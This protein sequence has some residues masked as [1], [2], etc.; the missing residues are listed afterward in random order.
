MAEQGWGRLENYRVVSQSVSPGEHV[1]AG[2]PVTLKLD[3]PV[4]RGPLGSMVEPVNHPT[5]IRI[6]NLVGQDYRQAMAAGDAFKTGI[7]VR[8]SSSGP[9]KPAAS[10]CGLSGFVVASQQPHAGK[11][12]RWGGTEPDGVGPK[13]ATVTI[14]LVSR[15]SV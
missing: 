15:T 11:K 7:F 2:T 3:T 12:V 10:A 9:L 1:S 8:V 14:T 5:Y 6:P 4:F 13:L